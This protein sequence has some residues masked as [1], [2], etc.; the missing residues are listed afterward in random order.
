MVIFCYIL[1]NKCGA[2]LSMCTHFEC[3]GYKQMVESV[4]RCVRNPLKLAHSDLRY[5]NVNSSFSTVIFLTCVK[6]QTET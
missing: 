2:L 6:K 3:D 4:V 5:D 1:V